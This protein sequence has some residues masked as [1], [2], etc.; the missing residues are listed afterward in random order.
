MQLVFIPRYF[1][2]QTIPNVRH[3]GPPTY[4]DALLQYLIKL[5]LYVRYWARKKK[6]DY[7]LVNKFPGGEIAI[8]WSHGVLEKS[9][10]WFW[11]LVVHSAFGSVETFHMKR[12]KMSQ[13]AMRRLWFQ[14]NES[15]NSLCTQFMTLDMARMGCCCWILLV[16][17]ISTPVSDNRRIVG[18][19]NNDDNVVGYGIK[20]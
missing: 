19:T 11:N 18:K 9:H 20:H 16:R 13:Y 15:L 14:H 1:Y 8:D 5:S 7:I 17:P 4:C 2:R 12:N 3:H 6:F 10:F